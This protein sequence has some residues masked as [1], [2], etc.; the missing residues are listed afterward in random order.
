M[1]EATKKWV[2]S[3][4]ALFENDKEQMC[5][6]CSKPTKIYE[7]M[8]LACFLCSPECQKKWWEKYEDA[9]R[10]KYQE[11]LLGIDEKNFID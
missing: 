1:D 11:G 8:G 5:S 2:D 7:D 9:C 3:D 6:I 10:P 4:N